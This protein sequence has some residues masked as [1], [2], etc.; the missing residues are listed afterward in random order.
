MK[1]INFCKSIES[2]KLVVDGVIQ[3]KLGPNFKRVIV[4]INIAEKDI[5]MSIANMILFIKNEN[6][7]ELLNINLFITQILKNDNLS[8]RFEVVF[9]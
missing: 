9:C 1:N 6:I 8:Y 2:R 5:E 7:F 4:N 3:K